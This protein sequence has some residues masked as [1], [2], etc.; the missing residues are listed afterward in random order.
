MPDIMLML[1][2]LSQSVDKTSLRRLGCLVEGLLAMTGRVTMRGLSRWTT[3]GGS[4]RTLQRFFNT[5]LS[6]GQVHWLV[7]RQHLLGDETQWLLAGDEVV[8]S[9]SGKKTHGLDRF[10]SSVVG[11]TIPGLCF[12]SLS[13][14]SVQRRCSYPLRLEP[15]IKEVAASCP[16]AP[17][18]GRGKGRGRPKGRRNGNRR[19]V[20]LSP[21]LQFVQGLLRQVL[22]LVCQTLTVRYFVFDGAFGHNRALQMV[23]RT[24]LELISKLRHNSALYRP[25]DGPYAGRGPRRKYGSKLDY[26]HLPPSCLKA[27]SVEGHVHTAIYQLPVWHKKFPDQLNVVILVKTNQRTGAQ[28]HVILFSSDLELG[29][30]TLIEYYRL[31]FQIEFNF[32]DA[33]QYWGLEDFMVVEPTPVYNSANLAM[34]MINLSQI[35]MRPV[36]EHCPGFSVNDLKAHFRGRKYVLEVLKLLPKM[37]EANIIDQALEQAANLGRI[38]QELSAA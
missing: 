25:Y 6:W 14:I 11:K 13:L 10:F 12:L 9:K 34:L 38:N 28:A 22:A 37:P 8:V 7:I 29:Y 23:R 5:S 17:K 1:S 18:A 35:L 33:K 19:E 36:R 16:K 27:T 30:E 24:G 15:I 21:Y 2:C 26:Q 3:C 20:S 31:R 32:R 4:Y